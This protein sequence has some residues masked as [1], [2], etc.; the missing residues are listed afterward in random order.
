MTEK[1]VN[2][3]KTWVLRIMQWQGKTEECEDT[4]D[5]QD[6]QGKEVKPLSE[7]TGNLDSA[8][9]DFLPPPATPSENREGEHIPAPSG[10]VEPEVS[11]G[12]SDVFSS[13]RP[14]EPSVSKRGDAMVVD[15]PSDFVSAKHSE[16]ERV[17][18]IP[19]PSG[20]ALKKDREDDVESN[21]P[22]SKEA[23]TKSSGEAGNEFKVPLSSD[24]L[25]VSNQ[26]ADSAIDSSS[27]F[28]SS[29][30][31]RDKIFEGSPESS[32]VELQE[33]KTQKHDATA[34]N[35][36]SEFVSAESRESEEERV[37][38]EP[39]KG[40]P[41]KD[42]KDDTEPAPSP[43]EETETEF[44]GEAGDGFAA[45]RSGDSSGISNRDT[46]SPTDT[47]SGSAGGEKR[48]KKSNKLPRQMPARR[49]PRNTV[50]KPSERT[51]RLPMRGPELICRYGSE[52]G[53]WEIVLSVPNEISDSVEVRHGE[54]VLYVK[55]GEC[56]L[57]SF[58]GNVTV[59]YSD[60]K[61]SEFRLFDGKSPLIFKLKNHGKGHGQRI[62]AITRGH[63][64]LFAPSD[65]T[66]LGT[67][68][69]DC[70]GCVDPEFLAHHFFRGNDDSA[71][72]IGEFEECKLLTGEG[73]V[74]RGKQVMDDSQNGCLFVGPPPSLNP[75]Q[76]IVYAQVGEERPGGWK[77][78]NF[79]PVDDSL[80]EILDGRQGRFFV[81]VY[82]DEANLVDSEEFRYC[83]NLAEILVD[84]EPYDPNVPM[85]PSPGGH[86]PTILKF[87]GTDGIAL[88]S[89]LKNDNP[90]VTS[91]QDGTIGIGASCPENDETVWSLFSERGVVEV[92][93]MFPRVWWKIQRLD[94][95][96]GEWLDKPFD[97]TREEFRD[98]AEEGVGIR[99]S[100]PSS[101]KT[102]FA[103]FND[104][105][106]LEFNVAEKLPFDWFI[107]YPEI[108]Q[109]LYGAAELKVRF[110]NESLTL[111]RIVPE[112]S[113][114][115]LPF[116]RVRRH[117][118]GWRCGKGFS[119]GELKN[120]GLFA[121]DAKRLG[122]RVDG[123]RR[124]V[125]R[126]NTDILIEVMKDA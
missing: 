70:E 41:E 50:V 78:G 95:D 30:R 84:D 21:A 42:E 101:V 94:M 56:K 98:R 68:S 22:L 53:K 43:T 39:S 86:P 63:F 1:I 120:A 61:I 6:E 35:V 54:K 93:I 12:S 88:N 110:G 108:V 102:G 52:E 85:L 26:N 29:V 5:N 119:I 47:V 9:S 46:A 33:I 125:H 77:S 36:S 55:D 57:S 109:S 25:S 34:E 14:I 89:K 17:R 80:E 31:N 7:N 104:D 91:G 83:S 62:G 8:V 38:A 74:L 13:S 11:V 72:C 48:E 82:N 15:I 117:D 116:V 96:S 44:S 118:G 79:N 67:S 111:V 40:E 45:P 20:N 126:Y 105:L 81:R 16:S 18:S 69:D 90:C 114:R 4:V 112:M 73:F 32:D 115:E 64:C 87:M 113:L 66:R 19:D 121:S 106:P 100:L 76:G 58:S 92:A 97:M 10:K 107:D 65:W 99:L 28:M 2:A 37:V 122:V 51:S 75:A 59:V 124:S 49:M 103:G 23:K 60:G 27:G 3:I 24:S 71:D 123:R